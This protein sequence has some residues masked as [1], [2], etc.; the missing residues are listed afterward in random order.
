[1]RHVVQLLLPLYDNDGRSI[2]EAH[3][4]EI[5]RELTGRFGGVTAYVRSPATGL[6]KRDDGRVDHD[7]MLMFE[8]MVDVL[9]TEWWATYR[10]ELERRFRQETIV[11]RAI[12][13][14]PL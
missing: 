8:V 11:A 6:W 7:E 1:M 10:A 12:A 4:A 13:I 9:D 3:F 14:Q 2:D 5:R